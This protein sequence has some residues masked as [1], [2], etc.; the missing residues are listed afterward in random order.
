MSEPTRI[1]LRTVQD[2]FAIP[3]E[4]LDACIVDF[5]GFLQTV[6]AMRANPDLTGALAPD[7]E[8]Y[9]TWI[10]DGKHIAYAIE[11]GEIREPLFEFADPE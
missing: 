9:F 10:D 5:I 6:R 8:T 2:F 3:D 7:A 11:G 4:K 1:V